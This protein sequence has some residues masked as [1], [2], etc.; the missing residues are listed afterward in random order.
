MATKK[1]K[2]CGDRYDKQPD[3]PPFRNWCGVDCALS[4]ARNAQERA[5]AKQ[6]AKAKR[7]HRDKE[8]AFKRETRQRKEK[9]KTLTD[10]KDA[11]QKEVNRFIKFRDWGKP[12]VSCDKPHNFEHQRHASHYRSKGNYDSLRFDEENINMSCATCNGQLSGNLIEYRL[13]LLTRI[14]QDG[15]DRLEGPTPL[16]TWTVEQLKE[17]GTKYR[18]KANMMEIQKCGR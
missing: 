1:C 15:V 17:L 3:H 18:L 8:Q 14:G 7:V 12:C 16:S 4:I 5:R 11:T 6:Q 9:L 13:R 10:Y 2:G